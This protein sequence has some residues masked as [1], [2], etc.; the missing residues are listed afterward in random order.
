MTLEEL[1]ATNPEAKSLVDDA[2]KSA[3]EPLTK[4][5]AELVNETKTSKQAAKELQAALTELGDIEGLK[6]I[7]SMFEQ[8]EELKLFAEGK[9]DEVFSKRTEKL[10]AENKKQLDAL[11]E[12]LEKSNQRASAFEARV[13]ESKIMNAAMQV[14]TLNHDYMEDILLHAR[15]KFSLS[16]DGEA[17]M[18][19]KD[20]QVVLGKDGKTPFMPLEWLSD[21]D[22][23][24]RWHKTANSGAG[25]QGSA[26]MKQSKSTITRAQYETMLPL[27]QRDTIMSGITVV[28]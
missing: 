23:T 25:A 24:G 14:K 12:K 27:Q 11:T 21:I 16:D 3:I 20:G 8:N 7:K 19:D 10:T 9:H 1:F 13:L 5:Q 15:N 17:I 26:S 6:K 4:K 18:I 22:T 2:I 28:D